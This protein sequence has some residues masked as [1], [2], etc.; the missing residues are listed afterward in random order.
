MTTLG[1]NS[2]K[3]RRHVRAALALFFLAPLVGEFLLG[4]LPITFLP[5]LVVLGPLY[6]GGS[7]LIRE[8]ARRFNLTWPAMTVLGLAFGIVE[9][10]F[11]TQSLFNPNYLGLR[12]LDYGYIPALGMGAWWTVF[13]LSLH[14]I[15]STAVP[16]ALMETL[17]PAARRTPWL[18]RFGFTVTALVFI[19]GCVLL[20]KQQLKS[21]FIASHA[22]FAGSAIAIVVLIA[23]A[24]LFGR[25]S[26]HGTAPRSGRAPAPLL[27][28]AFTMIFG[29]AFMALVRA[30]RMLA[31]L[32]DVSGL[33]VL[34]AA[35]IALILVWSRRAGWNERHR[36]A[37]AGGFLLTYAWYGF[38]QVPS[39][40]KVTLF[41]DRLGDV[42]FGAGA[43][44]LLFLAISRVRTEP[45]AG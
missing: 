25:R 38:V 40:G 18:G 41:V 15:W 36:L 17:T 14:T 16:I 29:A 24:F 44:L 5:L 4:N 3:P 10:A 43:L 31:P 37:V 45:V 13:V 1:P 27:V 28:G 8:S 30:R 26:L 39:V 9:E 35:G 20:T 12:L 2:E 19:A 6:G 42:V 11:T 21:G 32:E 33:V 23:L 22:Q 7:L 34:F